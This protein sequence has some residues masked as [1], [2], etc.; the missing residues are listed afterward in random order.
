MTRT[1]S[2]DRVRVVSLGAATAAFGAALVLRDPHGDGSWAKCPSLLLGFY[3]PGCGSLRGIHDLL[4]GHLVESV[5]HNLLLLPA[6]VWLGW[7][8]VA[9]VGAAWSRPLTGPP[10][11]SRFAIGLLVV[12]PIFMILRNLPGSPLAP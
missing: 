7:W 11:N 5:G 8:W 3:C 9:R 4:T 12:L 10:D 2:L 1:R 6:L